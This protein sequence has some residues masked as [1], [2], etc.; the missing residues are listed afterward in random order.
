MAHTGHDIDGD[1]QEIIVDNEK[2]NADQT[3]KPRTAIDYFLLQQ[4]Q[5]EPQQQE[6]PALPRS[7][8]S[9][10]TIMTLDAT[11]TPLPQ[12]AE[13]EREEQP[14]RQQR[15]ERQ[16]RQQAT[17][18]YPNFSYKRNTVPTKAAPKRPPLVPT[19]D[20]VDAFIRRGGW[21]R[22]GIVFQHDSG[23]RSDTGSDDGNP[24]AD[25]N[26]TDIIEKEMFC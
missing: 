7:H 10:S 20:N 26:V 13:R 24:G 1:V 4:R 6:R 11:P 21:K 16:V 5:Q 25:E 2:E 3:R 9:Q 8:W 15:L 12:E 14:E 22:R 18:S 17:A 19:A 23:Y